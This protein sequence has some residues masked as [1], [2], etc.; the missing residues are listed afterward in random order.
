VSAARG[1]PGPGPGRPGPGALAII[2]EEH[3]SLTAVTQSLRTLA[4]DARA[5]GTALD[6]ELFALV[7]DYIDH[8]SNRFHH[9]KEDDYLFAALRRRRAEAAE[10]LH[11]LEVEHA[12]RDELIRDLRFLLSRCR[13]GG[14]AALDAFVSAV[15]EYVDFH[16]RHLRLEEDV[17][18]PLAEAKL[19]EADWPPIDAAF[20]ANEDPLLG[21]RP[22]EDF[23]RLLDLIVSMAP[24]PVGVGPRR[25]APPAG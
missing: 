15:E 4:G 13:V 19:A 8:V 10:T 25:G 16:W 24:P 23:R 7:L 3:R 9:P 2:R 17:V 6:F 18:L 12:W 5:R 20:R 22:R 21:P 1:G 11:V 14:P